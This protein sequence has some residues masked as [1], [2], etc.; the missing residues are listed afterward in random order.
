MKI[1]TEIQIE[2]ERIIKIII[3]KC[4]YFINL[5]KRNSVFKSLKHNIIF[6]IE[7]PD[8][9]RIKDRGVEI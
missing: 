4:D 5:K 2:Q 8:Y 9:V 7:N 6:A 3:K 1:K